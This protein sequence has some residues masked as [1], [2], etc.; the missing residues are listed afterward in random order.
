MRGRKKKKKK[1]SHPVLNWRPN[2][3]E[4]C[5]LPIALHKSLQQALR[6]LCYIYS[7]VYE[8][9]YTDIQSD[10]QKDTGRDIVA[11]AMK[12]IATKTDISNERLQFLSS[13]LLSWCKI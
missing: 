9:T 7:S 11:S 8:F 4:A 6:N 12:Q 1:V 2:D 5:A 3:R 13:F 10:R